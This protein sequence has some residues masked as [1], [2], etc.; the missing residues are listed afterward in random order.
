MPSLLKALWRQHQVRQE[1]VRAPTRRTSTPANPDP[2]DQQ[3]RTQ[4]APVPTPAD[5]PPQATWTPL[6]R[7]GH[8]LAGGHITRRRRRVRPYDGHWGCFHHPLF[9]PSRLLYDREGSFSGISR[10]LL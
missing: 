3:R 5:E 7:N 2:F 8:L 1:R 10:R 4:P 9:E 6:R